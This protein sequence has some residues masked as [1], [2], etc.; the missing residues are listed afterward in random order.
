MKKR[1][2]ANAPVRQCTREGGATVRA[3]LV[4][5]S[6]GTQFHSKIGDWKD[7]VTSFWILLEAQHGM[8]NLSHR[9]QP[10]DGNGKHAASWRLLRCE[11]KILASG[12]IFVSIVQWFS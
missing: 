4:A 8:G 6:Y 12:D 10:Y 1:S 5:S 11:A 3:V 2:I 9:A 7:C